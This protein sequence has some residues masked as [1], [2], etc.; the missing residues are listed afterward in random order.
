MP[1]GKHKNHC[2][3]C[4]RLYPERELYYDHRCK[5][6]HKRFN[7]EINRSDRLKRR[8]DKYYGR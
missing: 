1:R 7:N 4:N 3:D 5:K 2:I 8:T 6:C